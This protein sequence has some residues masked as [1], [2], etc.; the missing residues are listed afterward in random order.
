MPDGDDAP[1]TDEERERL[2]GALRRHVADGRLDLEQFD[3][4]V[5][6][7]YGAATRVEARA[8]LDGLPLLDAAAS[9]RSTARRARA[10]H[11]E[12]ARI[13]QHW[14]ATGEVFR[15]PSSGRVMRVWVDP[16]DGSRHYGQT[17]GE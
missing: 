13:E 5:A 7:V 8:A 4:R 2:A 14:V 9:P 17:D 3:L 10:R 11:G 6:Q 12:A 15:D 16:T 1:P